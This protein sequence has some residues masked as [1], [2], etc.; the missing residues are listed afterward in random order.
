M[1]LVV[2][3]TGEGENMW[4]CLSPP[5]RFRRSRLLTAAIIRRCKGKRKR[6]AEGGAGMSKE[7]EEEV[8]VVAVEE[9]GGGGGR[10]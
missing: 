8:V 2:R 3:Y 6:L 5:C 4:S 1:A 7:R 10:F 9:G